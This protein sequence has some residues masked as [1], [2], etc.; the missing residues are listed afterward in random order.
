MLENPWTV[1]AQEQ[2]WWF[3]ILSCQILP[4]SIDTVQG[5]IPM[6]QELLCPREIVS[7]KTW[8]PPRLSGWV[9]PGLK[10]KVLLDVSLDL[11]LYKTCLKKKNP[12][13]LST[14]PTDRPEIFVL[15]LHLKLSSGYVISRKAFG[16]YTIL[17]GCYLLLFSLNHLLE[18]K[19]V[20]TW[21]RN[22]WKDVVFELQPQFALCFW[23]WWKINTPNQEVLF[24]PLAPK[25]TFLI[26]NYFQWHI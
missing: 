4:P 1:F 12:N 17:S 23:L 14:K 7:P 13:E 19:T 20:L 9:W 5:F 8:E 24:S 21:Q 6:M 10:T 2:G 15:S 18:I 11:Y 3:E 16:I 26:F 25:T 22:N